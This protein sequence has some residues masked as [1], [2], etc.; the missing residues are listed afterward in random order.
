MS[1]SEEFETLIQTSINEIINEMTK[2]RLF[3]KE[4]TGSG[5]EIASCERPVLHSSR[6]LSG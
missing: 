3:L 6:L 2:Q 5:K 1:A 4:E